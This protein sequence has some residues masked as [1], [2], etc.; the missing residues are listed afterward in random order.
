MKTIMQSF[1]LLCLT[2][3][4]C[5]S[6]FAQRDKSALLPE[7]EAKILAE[8]CSRQNPPEFSETWS[9][10]RSDIK[11][12]ESKFSDLKKLK[13]RGEKITNPEE[14]YMQYVGIVI[15]SKKFIYINAF[16]FSEPP[17]GWKEDALIGCDGGSRFWGVLYNVKAGKFTDLAVN[18]NP[19]Q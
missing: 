11:A 6:I 15:K 1:Y 10:T 7:S 5:C 18:G 19:F 12:M 8:Q 2:F 17:E 14:F 13:T 16:Y 9:P 3:L 4:M